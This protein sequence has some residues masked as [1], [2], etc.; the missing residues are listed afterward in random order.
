MEQ[1]R[2]ALAGI[3]GYGKKH[4]EVIAQLAK[5]GMLCCAAFCE[6][7]IAACRDQAAV[8]EGLGAKHYVNYQV[9]LDSHPEIDAVILVTPIPLHKRMFIDAMR[10]GIHVLTEKP[11]CI[12][13]EDLDEM[14]Q[15]A[16]A[17]GR[18]GAVNF[19]NTSGEAFRML[20]KH[21]Q[22][23]TIGDITAVTGIGMWRRTR[24]YF[25][26]TSWAGRLT[27]NGDYVLDGP[28]CNALSHL[29]NNC[30]IAAGGGDPQRAKPEW[31]Q[32]ELYR[33]N[34]IDSE[35]T[36]CIR[37]AAANGVR[38]HYYATLCNHENATPFIKVAGVR[39]EL[40]WSFDNVLSITDRSG[41]TESMD[42]GPEDL[43]RKMY[44]NLIDVMTG[45]QKRLFSSIED[46]RSFLLAANGAF[47]SSGSVH[48]IPDEALDVVPAA[49]SEYVH[50][51]RIGDYIQ[52]ASEQG[53]LFSELSAGWGVPSRK[54]D[55]SGYERLILGMAQKR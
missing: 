36:S 14:I 46:C 24:S 12:A 43:S 25:R 4:V 10:R 50:V 48:K 27:L 5:E 55:M 42:F 22:D 2:I 39:G 21:I 40:T 16:K 35:D 26:R 37:I 52:Q 44:V 17:S 11:P 19:Q 3:G 31:V 33:G 15:A 30:L 1:V 53:K 18:V 28:I 34:E 51:R 6:P 7:N 20:L 47:T 45:K 41:Q 23:G 54:V 38:I 32:A 9:M 49:D 13:I 29:L 8:L